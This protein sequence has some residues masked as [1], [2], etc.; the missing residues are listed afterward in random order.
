MTLGSSSWKFEGM[1]IYPDY[2]DYGDPRQLG[3][4][5]PFY[6]RVFALLAALALVLLNTYV[7]CSTDRIRPMQWYI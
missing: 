2:G 7:H 5:S 6:L 1:A 4:Y 3:A